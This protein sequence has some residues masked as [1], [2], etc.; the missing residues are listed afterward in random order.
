MCHRDISLENILI[1]EN[2][3]A[4]VIDLGMCLHIPYNAP[5][6]SELVCDV[7]AGTLRRLMYPQGQCGKPNYIS[8][9]VLQNSDAFDG[10]SAQLSL[11]KLV[12]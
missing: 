2:T 1:D 5:N 8:P 4:L 6:G 11:F 3:K 7:S 9:E 12:C 10:V